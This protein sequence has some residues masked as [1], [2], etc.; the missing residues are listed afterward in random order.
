[1][2]KLKN[3]NVC[4]NIVGTGTHDL[5]IKKINNLKLGKDIKWQKYIPRIKLLRFYKQNN[6]LIFPSLRD[7]GGMVLLEFICPKELLLLD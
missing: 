6:F 7:S 1:M 2:I 5:Q 4:F 3:K